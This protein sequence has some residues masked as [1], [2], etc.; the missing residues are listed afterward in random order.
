MLVNKSLKVRIYPNKWQEEMFKKNFGSCRFIHNQILD[1]LNYLHQN[2]KG[3]YKLNYKL[4]NTFLKQL[5]EENN[6]L[7]EIESTSLQQTTRDLVKSFIN[8]FKNPK[9]RKPKFHTKKNTKNSFR[10]TI[11]KDKPL[12]MGKYLHLR[13]YGK[14]RHRTSKKYTNT[15]NSTN[16]KINN[17]TISQENGK[18]YASINIECEQE[19]MKYTGKNIAFDINSNKN[20]WLVSN[21]GQKEKFNIDH[22]N[23]MIKYLNQQ[24]SLKKPNSRAYKKIQKRLWKYYNKRTNKLNDYAQKLS[25][26][27]VKKYD[28]AVFEKNPQNIKILIGGEQNMVFPLMKF[29][30]MLKY[31]FKWYKKES[32]GVVYVNPKNTSKTCHKCGHIHQELKVKTRKWKCPEC[33]TVLDRDVNAAINILN[34]WDN[35]AGL[36]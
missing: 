17:V 11:R 34:R 31:K 25:T 15:L 27:I 5:K 4:T 29:I 23:Q 18:Y 1:R 13:K 9:N 24:L 14:I 32:E 16:I 8:F 10:Q 6:F 36:V 20:S 21:N 26:K 30:D 28:N 22:E 12:V 3:Q 7:N 35:G 19:E 2:Y 33:K